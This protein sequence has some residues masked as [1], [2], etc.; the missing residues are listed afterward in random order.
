MLFHSIFTVLS[1]LEKCPCKPQ[2]YDIKRGC[3]WVYIAQAC[4]HDG[5]YMFLSCYVSVIHLLNVLELRGQ[6]SKKIRLFLTMV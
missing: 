2:F 4:Y 3:D 5:I 6:E 1:G